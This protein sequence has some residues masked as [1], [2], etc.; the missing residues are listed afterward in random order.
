MVCPVFWKKYPNGL[1]H[2]VPTELF[3]KVIYNFS[4]E[5]LKEMLGDPIFRCLYRMFLASG[6]LDNF[7][8]GDA[9]ISKNLD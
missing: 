3:N 7:S 2:V 1:S 8:A 9:T 5:S 6:L 4:K